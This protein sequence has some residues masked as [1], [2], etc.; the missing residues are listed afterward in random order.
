MEDTLGLRRR[1]RKLDLNSF[2]GPREHYVP[3]SFLGFS[4][5][6]KRSLT[7]IVRRHTTSHLVT[8]TDGN[9]VF[10]FYS[11]FFLRILIKKRAQ[12]LSSRF[13]KRSP[14]YYYYFAHLTKNNA[15]AEI[16]ICDSNVLLILSLA[17]S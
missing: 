12:L 6:R 15:K 11:F 10:I 13:E 8:L 14:I 5:R 4:R 3:P 16:F 9:N 2:V 17:V 1:V 7:M